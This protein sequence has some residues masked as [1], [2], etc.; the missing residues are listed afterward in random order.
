MPFSVYDA[1]MPKDWTPSQEHF[2]KLLAWFDTDRERAGEKYEEVRHSLIKIFLWRGCSR[3]ED[4][5][6]EVINRVMRKIDSLLETYQGDPSLYFYGV[7]RILLLEYQRKEFRLDDAL[8]TVNTA[9][10]APDNASDQ[11]DLKFTCLEVCLQ[12]L[13]EDDRKLILLYY[14]NE[15]SAKIDFRKKLA[16][17]IGGTTNALRVR[18]HRIRNILDE[19]ITNCLKQRI[20]V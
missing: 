12:K 8:T 13:S 1:P 7:A 15:K 6:D 16:E 11:A 17:Q 9:A 20:R 3:A 10:P 4:L 19:C 2:D 14:Q 5:A 18:V